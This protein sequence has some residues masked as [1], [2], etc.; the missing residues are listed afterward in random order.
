MIYTA[1]AF[2]R[3]ALVGNPSD[4]YFGKTISFV[5]RN[6]KATVRLWD[7]TRPNHPVRLSSF[8][9]GIHVALTPDGRTLAVESGV[10]KLRLLT[11]PPDGNT[12]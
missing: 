1:H 10:G 3:A 9:G 11:A 2:A 4:G 5:V 7:A 6:W 12:P 8:D